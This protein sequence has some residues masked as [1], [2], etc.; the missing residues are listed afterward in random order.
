M[1]RI[2]IL[3]AGRSA[4]ALILKMR[5]WAST[6]GWSLTI[7]DTNQQLAILKANN[8][9]NTT[10]I[11]FDVNNFVE[12]T[13]AIS[14]ADVV[15]SMLPPGFHI[16]VARLCLQYRKHFLNAS[17]VSPEIQS[18]HH[19][20][21]NA[22]LLFLNEC[23]LDP[24]IDHMSAMQVIDRIRSAG[25][26]VT[27]FKSFTGGLIDPKSDPENPWQYKFTWN[28][29]N[30]IMAGQGTAR[31]LDQGEFKYTPYQRLFKETTD[32]SVPGY[33]AFEGYANRD[34]LPYRK[35]YGLT[36]LKTMIRGTLRFAGFCPTW[37]ILVNLGCCDDS[38]QMEGVDGMTHRDFISA[39]LP[40]DPALPV[41]ERVCTCFALDPDGAEMRRMKWS[42]LFSSQ[43]VGLAVGTPAQILE[44]ILAKRWSLSPGDRDLV[45]MWHQ[46]IFEL[47][48]AAHEIQASFTAMGEDDVN[49]AM[50]RTVG[51][52]L[53]FATKLLM[54][55]K[56]RQR[57]VA[58]PVTP[59]FY[60]PILR[61]LDGEG[62]RLTE[63]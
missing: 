63:S 31:Y 54:E 60:D 50:S 58:I 15:I 10:A 46:F 34:S 13:H 11:S 17:Y 5:E 30:V 48:G 23:G 1:N 24:G 52:P 39:F 9:P 38:F 19:D 2:L 49:T 29:R 43:R 33:G 57:G 26:Q 41:E 62:L 42:G 8:D 47:G 25:G 6:F 59:E 51:L 4:T 16:V 32:V 55:G 56:L 61:D 22:D 37:H 12:A 53:A 18:L 20:A 7:G 45:V 35:T 44:H 14:G 40:A 36:A 27:S 21:V 28:P 3:G